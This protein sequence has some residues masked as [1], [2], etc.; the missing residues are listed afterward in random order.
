MNSGDAIQGCAGID[1]FRTGDIEKLRLHSAYSAFVNVDFDE[2][3]S[4][5]DID[6]GVGVEI[7]Y[8]IR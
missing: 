2:A 7:P 1:D 4:G 3:V 5:M 8:A 6:G